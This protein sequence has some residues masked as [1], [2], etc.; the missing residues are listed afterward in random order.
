MKYMRTPKEENKSLNPPYGD[1]SDGISTKIMC[2]RLQCTLPS[3]ISIQL[4]SEN[5]H[6]KLMDLVSGEVKTWKNQLDS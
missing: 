1:S 6:S 5:L 2:M 4:Q 3:H